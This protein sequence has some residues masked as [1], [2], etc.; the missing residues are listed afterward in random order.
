MIKVATN[1]TPKTS[2]ARDAVLFQ[3]FDEEDTALL[4][5]RRIVEQIDEFVPVVQILDF[6]VLHVGFFNI[7]D[8]ILQPTVDQGLREVQRGS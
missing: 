5:L 6:P 8:E 3:K 7:I 2:V 4:R 1:Y